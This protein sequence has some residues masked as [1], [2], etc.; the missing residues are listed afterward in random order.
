MKK[1]IALILLCALPAFG[2][3]RVRSFMLKTNG[4]LADSDTN[5]FILNYDKAIAAGLGGSGGTNGGTPILPSATIAVTPVSSSNRLDVV[6]TLTNNTTGNAATATLA[7]TATSAT[8]ATTATSATTA[9]TAAVA[10]TISSTESNRIFQTA[11]L[12]SSNTAYTLSTN[13]AFHSTNDL[14]FTIPGSGFGIS[15]TSGASGVTNTLNVTNVPFASFSDAAKAA[16]TNAGTAGGGL[17]EGQVDAR[18]AVCALTNGTA[19]GTA[20]ALLNPAN[21]FAGNGVGVTN[22]NAHTLN[23][24]LAISRLA[25]TNNLFV[26]LGDSITIGNNNSAGWSWPERAALLPFFQGRGTFTN[27]AASGSY[28]TNQVATFATLVPLIQTAVASGKQVYVFNNA[29]VNDVSGGYVT[30]ST[31][32]ISNWVYVYSTLVS[33]VVFYGGKFVAISVMNYGSTPNGNMDLIMKMNAGIKN[34]T[35]ITATVELN[36]VLPNPADTM[37]FLGDKLHPTDLGADKIARAVNGVMLATDYERLDR[38]GMKVSFLNP[39]GDKLTIGS[40]SDALN[41]IKLNLAAGTGENAIISFAS[42]SPSSTKEIAFVGQVNTAGQLFIGSLAGDT[43]LAPKGGSDLV[44][45]TSGSSSIFQTERARIAAAT[46]NLTLNTN[47]IVRGTISGNGPGITNLNFTA[48]TVGS[49]FAVTNA[50]PSSI[51]FSNSGVVNPW[52]V[53]TPTNDSGNLIISNGTAVFKLG[54]NGVLTANSITTVRS[55]GLPLTAITFPAT[56]VNWTN[57]A[58]NTASPACNIYLHINNVGV[59]GTAL[60]KNGTTLSSALIAGDMILPMKPGDYFSETYTVGTPTA[61]WE[62]Q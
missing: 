37:D 4:T 41:G 19:G 38:L 29:G 39:G 44:F 3:E 46:G 22:I 24:D 36:K 7:A 58:A 62:P 28:L 51:M 59:T 49:P 60:I 9:T 35:N 45:A 48:V 42:G 20:A 43:V 14:P 5:F 16:I 55:N 17:N 25:S 23:S 11:W 33:N 32:S 30:N 21:S 47:L 57:N 52:W 15:Q 1:I 13:A 27:A 54:T 31:S 8:T 50:G 26:F 10:T 40:S 56:T 34:L 2:A 53:W 6:G 61:V 18:V 12:Q